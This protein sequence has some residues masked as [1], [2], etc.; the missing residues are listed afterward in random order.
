MKVI[1]V[2]NYSLE[3]SQNFALRHER[4]VVLIKDIEPVLSASMVHIY[5]DKRL[6]ELTELA[7]AQDHYVLRI[8]IYLH[9]AAS[10]DKDNMR[11]VCQR[12]G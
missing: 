1:R 2:G 5:W 9:A 3:I 4:Q 6:M 12:H 8:R 7:S 11:S 10:L